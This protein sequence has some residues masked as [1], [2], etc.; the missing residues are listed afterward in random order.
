[1]V[2]FKL[3]VSAAR[4]ACASRVLPQAMPSEILVSIILLPTPKVSFVFVQQLDNLLGQQPHTGGEGLQATGMVQVRRQPAPTPLR[5]RVMPPDQAGS[6][7]ATARSTR[8]NFFFSSRSGKS[9]KIF[10]T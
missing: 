4:A 1:M 9:Q 10:S 7:R 6:E 2:S 5:V 3:E 8:R